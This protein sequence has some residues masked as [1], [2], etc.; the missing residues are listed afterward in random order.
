[1]LLLHTRVLDKERDEHLE[2]RRAQ[3]LQRG[4]ECHRFVLQIGCL[5]E[6]GKG[7]G[8]C[9]HRLDLSS[10][11]LDLEVELPCNCDF[12]GTERKCGS[13]YIFDGKRVFKLGVQWRQFALKAKEKAPL[14]KANK[15][16]NSFRSVGGAQ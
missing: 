1:M 4:I 11:G 2:R 16:A 15:R 13:G 3:K 14:R 10:F 8:W 6:R 12:I 9:S 5:C 7:N